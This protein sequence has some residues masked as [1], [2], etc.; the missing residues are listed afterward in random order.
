[1]NLDD[2]FGADPVVVKLQAKDRWEAI[3]EL[4]GHLVAAKKIRA[5]QKEAIVAAVKRRDSSMSTGI[6]FGIG[7]PHATTELVSEVV[8]AVGWAK[9]GIQFDALDGQPVDLVLLFLIPH[10]Q[11]QQ[12]LQ[13]LV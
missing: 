12:H 2:F 13:V 7:L 9:D 6:G 3:D 1:M 4:I 11:F 10:G 5:E 8:S